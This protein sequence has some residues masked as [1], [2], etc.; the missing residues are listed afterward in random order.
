MEGSNSQLQEYFCYIASSQQMCQLPSDFENAKKSF[1]EIID[2]AER[3]HVGVIFKT[4]FPM[5]TIIIIIVI[6]MEI[7]N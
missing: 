1:L 4:K 3:Y 7:Y 5:D 2:A 6:T